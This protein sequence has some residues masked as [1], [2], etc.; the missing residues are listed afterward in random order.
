[1]AQMAARY[2]S[3]ITFLYLDLGAT[4]LSGRGRA[5]RGCE[6]YEGRVGADAADAPLPQL[7]G[8]NAGGAELQDEPTH[9][10]DLRLPGREDAHQGQAPPQV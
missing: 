1:M 10:R 2:V 7:S 9:P 6:G 8:L 4:L 3:I 5:E